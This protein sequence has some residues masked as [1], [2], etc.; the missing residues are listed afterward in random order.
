MSKLA[1]LARQYA[2]KLAGEAE[3]NIR[4]QRTAPGFDLPANSG[5]LSTLTWLESGRMASSMRGTANA[6]GSIIARNKMPYSG[7]QDARYGGFMRVTDEWLDKYVSKLTEAV[8]L[9]SGL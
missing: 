4:Q 6:D 9:D 1:Q 5:Q 3:A 2:E 8:L 7:E